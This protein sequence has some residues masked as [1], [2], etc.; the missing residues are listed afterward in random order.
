MFSVANKEQQNTIV[1]WAWS[2][3]FCAT[4]V[5]FC[6]WILLIAKTLISLWQQ[7]MQQTNIAPEPLSSGNKQEP[8][9]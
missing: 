7:I 1:L 8:F 9:V 6:G 2:G 3:G 5:W 4:E